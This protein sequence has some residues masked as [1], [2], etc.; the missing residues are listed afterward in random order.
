MIVRNKKNTGNSPAR[1]LVSACLNGE[2][3]RYDG[4]T[5]KLGFINRLRSRNYAIISICPEIEAGLG[6]PRPPLHLVQNVHEVDCLGVNDHLLNVTRQLTGIA[7]RVQSRH[8]DLDACILKSRS[9]S[10]GLGNTKLF[11]KQ[12]QLLHTEASGIFA[13]VMNNSNIPCVNECSLQT[14]RQRVSFLLQV[15]HSAIR[16]CPDAILKILIQQDTSTLFH[17]ENVFSTLK[18]IVENIIIQIT[19]VNIQLQLLPLLEE[20]DENNGLENLL[21]KIQDI[22]QE[23][24]NMIR[25]N[26]WVQAYLNAR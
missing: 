17:P 18:L 3:V 19:D 1:I 21:A 10:C 4:K 13:S 24:Q 11:N 23:Y 7:E 25:F 14:Y 9:P 8:P 16:S 20:I 2:P 6:C 22:P 26:G 12:N 5:A 15:H